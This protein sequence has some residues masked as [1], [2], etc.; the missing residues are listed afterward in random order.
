MFHLGGAY[1]TALGGR[2]HCLDHT[3]DWVHKQAVV[4]PGDQYLL[5]AVIADSR[6]NFHHNASGYIGHRST[7]DY[8]VSSPENIQEAVRVFSSGD[9]LQLDECSLPPALAYLMPDWRIFSCRLIDVRICR[10]LIIDSSLLVSIVS[11]RCFP[12]TNSILGS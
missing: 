10:K 6:Q 8:H 1:V 2:F 11:S 12:L 9:G 3:A 5:P 7:L 4:H